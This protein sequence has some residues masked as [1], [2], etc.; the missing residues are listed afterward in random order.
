MTSSEPRPVTNQIKS[1]PQL[2]RTPNSTD[3][4]DI[5]RWTNLFARTSSTEIASN[6]LAYGCVDWYLYNGEPLGSA[7]FG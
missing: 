2:P 7:T 1:L 5:A 4:Q 6:D 3:V